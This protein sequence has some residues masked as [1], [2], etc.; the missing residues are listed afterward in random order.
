M[1]G[2]SCGL[3]GLPARGLALVDHDRVVGEPDNE[4]IGI[5]SG[6]GHNVADDELVLRLEVTRVIGARR[7][8]ARGQ[9]LAN[10]PVPHDYL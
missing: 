2:S 4:H 9:L 3:T 6:I 8:P 5:E 1:L 10:D 7:R